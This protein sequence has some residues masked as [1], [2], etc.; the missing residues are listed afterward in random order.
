MDTGNMFIALYDAVADSVCFELAF[1][2]G[3]PITILSRQAG[4][5]RVEEIIHTGQSILGSGLFL[6][7][8]LRHSDLNHTVCA[9]VVA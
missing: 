3:E 8:Q 1:K 5:D 6:L 7:C 9:D 2:N 4:K